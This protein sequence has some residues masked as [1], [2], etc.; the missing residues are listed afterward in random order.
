[1]NIYEQWTKIEEEKFT[2]TSIKKE[3]IM[4][5][6]Y[7]KSSSSIDTL[8]T[9]LKHKMAWV[10]FFIAS[11]SVMMIWNINNLP[12]VV[13]LAIAALLYGIGF[14]QLWRIYRKMALNMGEMSTLSVVKE[15]HRLIKG[16]LKF[17]SDFFIICILPIMVVG[18]VFLGGLLAGEEIMSLLTNLKLLITAFVCIVVAG[19]LVKFLGDKMNKYA[20]GSFIAKLEEN[21][22]EMEKVG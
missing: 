10:A 14:I 11:F 20:Y 17:E 18:A 16:A 1:M 4:E 22:R 9:R 15:N 12:V 19:P 8:K 2:N 3:D 6:I 13:I 7:K 21:I 5:A